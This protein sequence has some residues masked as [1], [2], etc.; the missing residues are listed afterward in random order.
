MPAAQNHPNGGQNDKT[1]ATGPAAPHCR[2]APG[3]IVSEDTDMPGNVPEAGKIAM[4]K[5]VD[6]ACFSKILIPAIPGMV[7]R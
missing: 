3:F 1:I 2:I 4:E 7:N 5:S 6:T